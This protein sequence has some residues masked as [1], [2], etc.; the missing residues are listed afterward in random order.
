MRRALPY[1]VGED[2]RAFAGTPMEC[3][4]RAFADHFN[5]GAITKDIETRGNLALVVPMGNPHDVGTVQNGV[6]RGVPASRGTRGDPLVPSNT[7]MG[8]VVNNGITAN[9][10]IR[11]AFVVPLNHFSPQSHS[12]DADR[13]AYS[14]KVP[15]PAIMPSKDIGMPPKYSRRGTGGNYTIPY[16]QSAPV[17]PTSSQWLASR[18]RQS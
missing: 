1:T 11:K 12:S 10:S 14:A 15:P 6:T 9:D 13:A 7:V 3:P 2:P 16:P 5:G 4:T 17:W 18:V 8:G